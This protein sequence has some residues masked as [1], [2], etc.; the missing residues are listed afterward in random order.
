MTPNIWYID[1]GVSSHM[2]GVREHFSDLKDHEV[3]MEISLR[4]DTIIIVV[5]SGTMTFQ[6][7]TMPPISFKDVL[8]VPGLKKNLISISTL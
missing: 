8:Y 2:T 4:D 6:R 1:S 3:N 5:G 7:D